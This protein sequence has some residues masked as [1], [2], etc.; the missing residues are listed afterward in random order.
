MSIHK[1][2]FLGLFF[3]FVAC[4]NSPERPEPILPEGYTPSATTTPATPTATPTAEPAQN[5]A[6]VWHY[7]CPSGCAGGG[8]AAGPCGSCGATLAHNAAYHQ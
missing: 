4:N 8:G 5:A 2:L 6:G 3:A 7:T 1:I